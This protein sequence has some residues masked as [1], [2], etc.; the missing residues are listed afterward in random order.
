MRTEGIH[1]GASSCGEGPSPPPPRV[2]V[3]R[4]VGHKFRRWLDAVVMQVM[5]A[6]QGARI[7]P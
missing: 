6:G 3:E 7:A 2:G 1:R 4:E 5:V